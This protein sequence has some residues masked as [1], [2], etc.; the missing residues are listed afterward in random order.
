MGAPAVP[1]RLGLGH[2]LDRSRKRVREPRPRLLAKA[3]GAMVQ[4][5]Q[6]QP[7]CGKKPRATEPRVPKCQQILKMVIPKDLR[8]TCPRY[9][10][11]D[12]KSLGTIKRTAP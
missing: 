6:N 10:A 3:V 1:G 4:T 2:L 9:S 8:E 7:E 11:S 12:V 5:G